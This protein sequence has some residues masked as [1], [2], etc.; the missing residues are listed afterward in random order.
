MSVDRHADGARADQA[1]II[2]DS[3]VTGTKRT[4]TYR[5]LRDEVAVLAGL[6]AISA[7]A[8]ATGS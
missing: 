2:H 8:G 6:L 5:A 1:A 4:I 3:P 7:S